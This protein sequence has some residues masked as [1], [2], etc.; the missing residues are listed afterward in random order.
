VARSNDD[1]PRARRI[2]RAGI[3]Y[4]DPYQ[5]IE[6]IEADFDAFSK[7]YFV[8]DHGRRV[9]IVVEREGR[10]LLARQYRLL[11]DGPSLEIPG[12]GV[13][14]GETPRQSALRECLEETGVRCSGAR[15]LVRYMPG[16]DIFRN[17]TEIFVGTK[18]QLPRR[19]RA[20][21]SEV[22]DTVW[23]P[24]QEVA[25]MIFAGRIA[26]GLTVV[27][28]LAFLHRGGPDRH[29]LVRTGP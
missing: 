29:R 24:V 9:G 13:K 21:R 22:H 17:P 10:I 23:L 16:M 14:R 15:T 26:C 5:R 6:R 1:I 19:F 3:A 18:P 2:R 7:T 25:D 12:G 11:V 8:H 20:Q 28:V 4:R 27:G